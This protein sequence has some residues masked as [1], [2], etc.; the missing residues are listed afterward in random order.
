MRWNKYLNF[1]KVIL[2]GSRVTLGAQEDSM[3]VK[4]FE[5]EAG[6]VGD[7]SRNFDGGIS[8][9]NTLM[10]VLS[11]G[12][13]FRTDKLWQGGEFYFQGMSTHGKGLSAHY[14]GDQQVISSIENG[15]YWFF[16]E[17]FYYRQNIGNGWLKVGLQDLNQDF[18]VSDGGSN[19]I[20]S[21]FGIPSTYPLNF[22]APIYPK[23]ALAISG[24]YNFT[25]KWSVKLAVFDGD[26]GSL[27]DDKINTKW[28]LHKQEGFLWVGELA[29]KPDERLHIKGGWMY[30]TANFTE[31]TDSSKKQK[32][33]YGMY[34]LMD[35]SLVK[36]SNRSISCFAQIAYHP[37]KVNY[38]PLYVGGGFIVQGY[39]FNRANDYLGLGAAYARF[40]DH[41]YECDIECCYF[42]NLNAH[43][44]IV[45]S[46]H[47]VLHPGGK[48]AD[49][50]NA[51]AGI[52]RVILTK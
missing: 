44:S 36:R 30:H 46:V 10:G 4:V 25:D 48:E 23:T 41:S 50:S 52:L 11:V 20:N 9:G 42:I 13:T 12:A 33:V 18:L 15:D 14:V 40:Y 45:P 31:I 34:M 22:S 5:W 38:N 19:F 21:S 17:K 35:Y 16:F 32:G 37:S 51:T 47:Y 24:L 28:R 1:F 8:R 3:Q 7:L 27:D 49:L 26:C 6:Y 39:L 43:I 29:F 2:L